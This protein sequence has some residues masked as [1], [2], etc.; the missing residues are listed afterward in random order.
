MRVMIERRTW[1]PLPIFTMIQ[2]AG[3]VST[4]EMHRSF[5]MGIG[6][7][8]VASPGAA[9]AIVQRL[10]EAGE[11]AAVIGEVQEGHSEVVIV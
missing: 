2:D 6:L 3:G 1:T 4:D 9:P 5:N 11:S 7:V 10:N 8:I